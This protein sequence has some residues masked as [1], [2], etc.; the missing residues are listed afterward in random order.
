MKRAPYPDRLTSAPLA[1]TMQPIAIGMTVPHDAPAPLVPMTPPAAASDIDADAGT[2]ITI[3]PLVAAPSVANTNARAYAHVSAAAEVGPSIYRTAAAAPLHNR[4]VAAAAPL[5]ILV[6][7]ISALNS[8]T[9][10]TLRPGADVITTTA[11]LSSSSAATRMGRRSSLRHHHA[12]G[13]LCHSGVQRR[14]SWP[15]PSDRWKRED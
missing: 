15:G 7:T 5:D 13:I 6:T 2:A 3:P 1:V 12:A 9:A 8:G 4:T 14:W 11:T 10:S